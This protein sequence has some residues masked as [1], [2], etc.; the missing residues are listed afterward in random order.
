M[1]WAE[2]YDPSCEIN[3]TYSLVTRATGMR[4]VNVPEG[5]HVLFVHVLRLA[6]IHLF[7]R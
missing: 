2:S 3:V 6:D 4:F 7:E 1:V 5:R